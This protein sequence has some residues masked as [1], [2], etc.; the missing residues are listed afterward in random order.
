MT[1]G[2]IKKNSKLLTILIILIVGIGSASYLIGSG[3]VNINNFFSIVQPDVELDPENQDSSYYLTLDISP[4]NICEGDTIT[5]EVKSNMPRAI[6]TLFGDTGTG[7]RA[8]ENF[9][10]LGNGGYTE[11]RV[12]SASGTVIFRVV[13]AD[14]ELNGKVSNDE[15]LTSI[16]CASHDDPD[17]PPEGTLCADLVVPLGTGD[18]GAFCDTSIDCE[19]DF[20]CDNYYDPTISLHKC[21]CTE[22]FF[23]QLN[24]SYPYGSVCECPPNSHEQVGNDVGDYMCVS[25]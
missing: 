5:G 8:I 24:Y 20:E 7:F 23:C 11:N 4:N 3:V 13:C 25:D 17:T 10:L 22:T 19:F 18:V 16:V 14:R 9:E 6:C 12:I 1:D 15:R 2:F 21:A